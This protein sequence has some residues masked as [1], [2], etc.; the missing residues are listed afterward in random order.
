MATMRVP[1]ESMELKDIFHEGKKAGIAVPI[2]LRGE[3]AVHD[4][5]LLEEARQYLVAQLT[6]RHSAR[7]AARAHVISLMTLITVLILL[8]LVIYMY[9]NP[10]KMIV[11]QIVALAH[12]PLL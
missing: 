2:H 1:Y 6:M 12:Y 7:L 3:H 10:P 4:P 5:R 11:K 8:G 9:F